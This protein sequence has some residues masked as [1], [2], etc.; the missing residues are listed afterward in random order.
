VSRTVAILLLLAASAGAQDARPRTEL[1]LDNA[2]LRVYR[3]TIPPQQELKF[4][5]HGDVVVIRTN[6]HEA[7]FLPGSQVFKRPNEQGTDAVDLIIELKRHWKAPVRTC[8][9][10]MT[11]TR[12]T[13]LGGQV[14]G[15]ATTLFTN[16]YITATRHDAIPNASISSSYYSEQGTDQLLFVPLTDLKANFGGT[17]E[18]LKSGQPYFS[19]A[20]EVEISGG[21]ADAKWMVL[22][23]HTPA[24]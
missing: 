12:D 13:T 24:Q 7:A 20:S 4:R 3:A 1:V 22:R 18:E 5:T 8:A 10:P 9:Q 23:L 11:C 16:G 21:P 14:V 2:A 17:P 6:T 15:H 19:T